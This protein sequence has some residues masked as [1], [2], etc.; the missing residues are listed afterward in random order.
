MSDPTAPPLPEKRRSVVFE[1]RGTTPTLNEIRG[2]HF[3]EYAKRREA[4]AWQVRAALNAVGYFA[5]EP[6]QRAAVA[7]ARYSVGSPD[8]DG[9]A[10]GIKPLLDSLVMPSASHPNGLGVILDDRPACLV[11]TVTSERAAS[12]ADQHMLVAIRELEPL[13]VVEKPKRRRGKPA[14]AKPSSAAVARGNRF[15]ARRLG[16]R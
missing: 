6:M 9:V 13:P 11:L 10:G 12:L 5:Q 4:M 3:H 7:I 8:A 14:W 15:T 16:L 2:M 1:L